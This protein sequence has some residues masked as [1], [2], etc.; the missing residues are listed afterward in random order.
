MVLSGPGSLVGGVWACARG[1]VS[2]SRGGLVPAPGGGVRDWRRTEVQH[3][4]Y[5]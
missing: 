2:L 5:K 4:T 3:V 1:A